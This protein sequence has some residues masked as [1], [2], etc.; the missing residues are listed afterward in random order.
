M[1][2]ARIALAFRD[3]LDARADHVLMHA[4]NPWE[5]DAAMTA[6]GFAVGVCEAQDQ[7]GIDAVLLRRRKAALSDLSPVLPRMVAEGRLGRKTGVGWYRYPGGGGLVIDPLVEDLL[8][9]EAWF[10][11]VTRSELSDAALVDQVIQGIL[12]VALDLLAKLGP[13]A[14]AQIDKVSH[15][16]IGFPRHTGGILSH[17]RSLGPSA[18]VQQIG[19]D[20][21]VRMDQIDLLFAQPSKTGQP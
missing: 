19:A 10:A 2:D 18:L 5:L 7:D 21:P 17:A 15:T 9:E 6:F 13:A 3:A 12:T 20:Q 14:A 8:R 11:G 4:T 16:A 1:T